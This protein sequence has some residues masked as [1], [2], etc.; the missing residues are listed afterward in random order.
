MSN[1]GSQHLAAL[2]RDEATA[3]HVNLVPLE[4]PG[5]LYKYVGESVWRKI[6]E[7]VESFEIEDLSRLNALIDTLEAKK[8]EISQI[9]FQTPERVKAIADL[10]AFRALHI[11]DIKKASLLFWSR[12]TSQKDRRKIVKRNTMTLP[13]GGTAFGL[14]EQQIKDAKKHGIDLLNFMEHRWGAWLGRHVF[15]DCRDSLKRPMQLLSVFENAGQKAEDEG[16]FLKWAVP[17]T[18]FPVCQHYVEGVTK[19]VYVQYGPNGDR[20]STGYFTNTLQLHVCFVEE[21][22]LSKGKQA[23]GASPNCIHS[24]DAAHMMMTSAAC[25]FPVTSIHDSYGCH[26]S[27]MPVLFKVVRE[28]FLKLYES[29]PLTLLMEQIGGD[30]SQV[31]IGTLDL[32][33]IL[34]S[35]YAFA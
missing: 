34:E 7:A 17:V 18:N 22:V 15:D 35:E 5:D 19:R 1:N 28:Q 30:I 9:P 4:F 21:H 12:V 14:G 33:L 6:N 20:S 8:K 25:D 29:D 2:T 11:E 31:R 24:L 32:R 3:P 13:Y 23:L 10:K 27:D 16:R 26:Y